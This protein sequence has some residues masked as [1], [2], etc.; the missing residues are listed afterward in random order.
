MNINLVIS[1]SDY[2][3]YGL[4]KASIAFPELIKIIRKD[5]FRETLDQGIE[6]AEKSGLSGMS[7][8]DITKEVK[9]TRKIAKNHH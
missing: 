6:L 1:E 2:K 5:I 8:E 3:K 7:I 4:G 9:A